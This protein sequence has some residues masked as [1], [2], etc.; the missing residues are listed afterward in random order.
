MVESD[1]VLVVGGTSGIGAAAASAF[2]RE[3]ARVLVAGRDARRGEEIAGAIDGHF[4][5]VDL[6]AENQVRTLFETVQNRFGCLN[7]LVNSGGAVVAGRAQTLVL[8]HW[9]RLLDINLTGAFLTCQ[10]AVPLLRTAARRGLNAAIVNVGSLSG[11]GGDLAMPAYNAA[12]AGLA[13]F[14]RSLALELAPEGIRVNGVSPGPIDT[15]MAQATTSNPEL[16]EAY[17]ATIPLGRFGRPE[18]V[19]EAIAY[20][21]SPR[22]SFITGAELAIDGGL[23]ARS[24]LP[25]FM[26]LSDRLT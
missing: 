11:Q 10:H 4:L 14:T 26:S 16:L 1:I 7:V 3:G 19:A 13:N 22:A 18:E 5:P 21:A 23:S 17:E 15:P 8:E 24:G 6:R 12:K 25:D 2:A 9:Q 20:L